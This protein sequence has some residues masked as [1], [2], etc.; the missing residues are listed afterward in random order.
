MTIDPHK[1]YTWTAHLTENTCNDCRR[2]DG[3]T[4]TGQEWLDHGLP[5]ENATEC[6]GN[7][8]CELIET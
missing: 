6:D 8:K 5:K 7:C 1:N 3:Q 4:R 2:L